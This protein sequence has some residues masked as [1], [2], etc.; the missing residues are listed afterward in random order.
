MVGSLSGIRVID[1][2]TSVAGPFAT[3]IL[4]DLGADVI[5]VERPGTGDDTRRWGPP[6]WEGANG[7]EG[8][9]FT[10]LNRNKRSCV[11]DLKDATDAA[12][13]R[14]LL[15]SADVLVQNLRPGTLANLGFGYEEVFATNPGIIYCDMTG[16]GPDGS[17]ADSPAYDPL[18]QAF[19][20]LM[21]LNGETGRPPVRVPASI[22]D[23]GTGM[24]TVI[25]A[26]DAL[27]AREKTGSGAHV[28]TSLL[29]TALMWLPT[30]FL[31]YFADGSVPPRFGSGAIGIYPYAAFPTADRYIIIAAGNQNLWTRLCKAIG[32]E[33]LL[34]DPRFAQNPDRV[35]HR[36]ELAEELSATLREVPSREWLVRL[37]EVGVP[38]T[39]IQT[40]DEVVVHDQVQAIGGFADVPHPRIDDFRVINLPIQIDGAYPSTRLVPPE[41]GE[42]TAEIFAELDAHRESQAT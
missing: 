35:T 5:K 11:L 20:G 40:I 24:W 15:D 1:V 6:F 12:R 30:Q 39:P 10:A 8:C 31:G 19:G 37:E 28:H 34:D 33:D 9:T 13:F 14:E 7:R 27:R 3:Q 16:Y 42:H 2:T 26:L 17:L 21:S 18:M 22:L 25:A 23:Q 4:A 36:D 29:N 32:R 41:L 38:S